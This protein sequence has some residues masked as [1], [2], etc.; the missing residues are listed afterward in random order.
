[1]KILNY[2]IIILICLIAISC[3]VQSGKQKTTKAFVPVC[4]NNLQAIVELKNQWAV[5]RNKTTNDIPTWDDLRPYFPDR[6]SNNIP[7]CPDGGVYNIGRIGAPPTCSIG[8]FEHSLSQM[9]INAIHG[10]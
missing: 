2:Y 7:T 3:S 8:G 9:E 10:P 6:W 4:R 1:M 5:E